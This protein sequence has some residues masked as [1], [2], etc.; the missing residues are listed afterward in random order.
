M[1]SFVYS[2]HLKVSRHRGKV[3][4][5]TIIHCNECII[6][7]SSIYLISLPPLLHL[8]HI[9]CDPSRIGIRKDDGKATRFA[10]TQVG[11]L[12]NKV[13][14]FNLTL[15]TCQL[16]VKMKDTDSDLR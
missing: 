1:L 9:S 10:I 15:L 3:D 2:L 12:V 16:M 4:Y 7:S 13:C 14:A 6:S 5:A 11:E 8:I